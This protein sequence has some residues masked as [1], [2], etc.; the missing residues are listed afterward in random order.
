MLITGA[1]GYLGSVL[2]KHFSSKYKLIK[3]SYKN[4]IKG[5]L[6][7]DLTDEEQ[8]S[9]FAKSCNPDYILHAAGKKAKFCE[10]NPE[11]SL[12]NFHS[13]ELITK[14]F[15]SALTY[16]ISSDFVFD[17]FKGNFKETDTPNPSTIYGITKLKGEKSFNLKKHCII[18]TSGLFDTNEKGFMNYVI[19]QLSQGKKV[20]AFTNIYNTPTYLPYFC[21]Y[22]EA[23]I[24]LNLTGLFH[25]CGNEKVSRFEFSKLIAKIFG[26]DRNLIVGKMAP[27]SFL[28][29]IDSSLD[30]SKIRGLLN[31]N[32]PNLKTALED[33]YKNSLNNTKV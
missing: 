4:K 31:L 26:Y 29:P 15:P 24:R 2:V 13:S 12:V 14:Y 25:V 21:N 8:V 5:H 9:K 3:L 23:M 19:S 28:S 10:E 18:R 16:Y 6:I 7:I 27:K 32:W 1:S 17:G 22:L 33:M 20:E 30:N 11:I